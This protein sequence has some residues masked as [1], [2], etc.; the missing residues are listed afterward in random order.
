MSQLLND[1]YPEKVNIGKKSYKEYL[2]CSK[3]KA[4]TQPITEKDRK[5]IES[6]KLENYQFN[7]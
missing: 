2:K 1:I 4:L 6:Y 3:D 5:K 7:Y